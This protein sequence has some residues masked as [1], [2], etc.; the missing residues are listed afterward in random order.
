MIIATLVLLALPAPAGYESYMSQVGLTKTSEDFQMINYRN[1][2]FMRS[3]QPPVK[4][5][6]DVTEIASAAMGAKG[7]SRMRSF[8]AR[9]YELDALP[10]ELRNGI[11]LGFDLIVG[12]SPSASVVYSYGNHCSVTITVTGVLIKGEKRGEVVLK[13]TPPDNMAEVAENVATLFLAEQEAYYFKPAEVNFQGRAIS[14]LKGLDDTYYIS[15]TDYAQKSGISYTLDSFTGAGTLQTSPPL[16]FNLGSRNYKISGEAQSAD[17][18]VVL[19]N[20]IAY[21][22]QSMLESAVK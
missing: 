5:R 22:P 7:F 16:T 6:L 14:A 10:R 3:E 4:V 9:V 11:K 21:I 18:I 15:A 20:G 2:D 8:S 12:H 13:G 19:R 17:H 1:Y